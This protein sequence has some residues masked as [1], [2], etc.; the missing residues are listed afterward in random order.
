VVADL[1]TPLGQALED[2]LTGYCRLESQDAL[3]LSANGVGVVTFDAGVPAAAYHTGTDAGGAE[4]LADI[5]VAGPY[6]IE[7]FELDEGALET[8]HGAEDLAVS[9]TMPARRLAG[10][11]ELADRTADRVTDGAA[12]R[13]QGNAEAAAYDA[14]ESF[15]ADEDKIEAIRDRARAEAERRATEWGFD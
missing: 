11:P 2:R 12:G 3:L 1:A 13:Q 8:V 9:P 4:A 5:A 10:D 6:R 15:L 14:V 7:L